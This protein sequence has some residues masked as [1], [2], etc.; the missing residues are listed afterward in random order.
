MINLTA[1]TDR[2]TKP[3]SNYC[4]PKI[5]SLVEEAYQAV[6][7]VIQDMDTSNG[8][9]TECDRKVELSQTIGALVVE[10][11]TDPAELRDCA[12]ASMSLVAQANQAT[13]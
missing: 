10:G 3:A 1:S 7:A 12:L 6:W 2:A 4:D 5:I 11:I 13:A 8:A 9:N